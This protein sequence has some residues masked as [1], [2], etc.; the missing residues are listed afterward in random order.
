MSNFDLLQTA[1]PMR[2]TVDAKA[3]SDALKNVAMVLKKSVVPILEE[4]S[5]R[6]SNG[7]CILTATDMDTWITTAIPADGNDFSFVFSRTKKVKQACHCF[8]GSLTLELMESGGLVHLSCGSRI[9]EFD[10]YSTDCYPDVP[11]TDSNVSFSTNAA[12]LLERIERVAYATLKPKQNIREST[13]CVEFSGNQVFA[14]DGYRA[15][16]DDGESDFPQPFLIYAE[17]LHYLKVFGEQQVEFRFSKPWLSVTDG[18]TTIIFHTANSE[19]FNLESAIP[20]RYQEEFPVSPKE[21][22][23]ELKYLKDIIPTTQRPYVYLRGNELLM[24][25]KNRKYSTAIKISRTGDTTIGFN[26]HYLSDALKQFRKEEHVTFKISGVHS[27]VVIEAE[28]RNDCAM[29]LPVRVELD[30]TA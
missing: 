6:F 2:A 21:F 13:A 7:Q 22:L 30:A 24:P 5:V 14:L 12:D 11:E 27:P 15:A 10:T 3:F 4:V 29:I 17:P 20:Q 19:P 23:A 8:S 1:R 25:V 26:L 9:G 16:W 28:G 18:K